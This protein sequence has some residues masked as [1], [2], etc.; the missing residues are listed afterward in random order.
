MRHMSESILSMGRE[1]VHLRQDASS[2]PKAKPREIVICACQRPHPTITPS[3][4]VP[5]DPHSALSC[6]PIGLYD[7]GPTTIQ[8]RAVSDCSA[9]RCV[10]FL[11]PRSLVSL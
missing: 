3:F 11:P 8:N 10:L 7:A 2:G 4:T 5:P 1:H 9:V 6:L